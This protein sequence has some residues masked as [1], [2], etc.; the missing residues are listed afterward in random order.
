MTQALCILIGAMGGEGGGVLSD[1]L[2]DAA[3]QAGFPVQSTS[4]PGV[5]QRTGATTYY[6]EIFPQRRAELGGREPVLSLTPTAG[7]VD[8]MVASELVEA[9]RA[10]QNG[11]V[12]PANTL[13]IASTH[14]EYAVSEKAAMGDGRFD[15][16]RVLQAAQAQ[17]RA[18]VLL[19]MRA[20]AQQHG[21]VINTVLFG[22][23]AGS[24]VLPFS[25]EECEQAIERSGKSVQASLRGF[26]AGYEAASGRV[27][28]STQLAER[29]QGI[30]RLPARA[31]AWPA[32]LHEVLASGIE[33]TTE[34]Q[35]PRYAEQYL[36]TVERLLDAQ[37]RLGQSD[38]A[39]TREAARYL[40]LWMCYEDVVRV[41]QL[42]TRRERLERVR[43]EVG[44]KTGDALRTTEYLKPGIDEI[45]SLLPPA[46][47][48][49]LLKATEGRSWHR[50]LLVRTD[51]LRGFLVLCA[52]RSFKVLRR[53]GFRY[54]EEQ[55][56]IRRWL[57]AIER[58]LPDP[59]AALEIALAGN[60]VKGYGETNRRGHR[61]LQALLGEAQPGVS[62]QRLRELRLAALA[63][64]QGRQLSGA[65]GRPVVAQ[66]IRIVR[67][68]QG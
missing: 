45:A 54:A 20:L 38:W 67:R 36:D 61:H 19:D 41:A 59:A 50:G 51:T 32:A 37:R 43:R 16:E 13:L 57:D 68:P 28:A 52:L 63:D 64:P 22:A 49:A 12:H 33:L 23:M 34:Y 56:A 18:A 17:A 48:R 42:K 10:I 8:L 62:A 47:A 55:A 39:V 60:L 21:T 26:A 11:Y 66:P 3:M 65:L 35:D 25:R 53:R 15:S 9:G 46:L 58:L 24:G 30:D 14:R 2:V 31:R 27:M 6:V 7:Q 4:V 5:A 40:A 29:L 1:W 44:V